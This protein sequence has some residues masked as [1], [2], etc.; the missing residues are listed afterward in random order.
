MPNDE[1]LAVV[2]A[3]LFASGEPIDAERIAQAVGV[4]LEDALMLLGRLSEKY[5]SAE[6]GL[7]LLKL[8]EEYQISTKKDYASEIR[9]ALESKKSAPLSNAAMEVLAI[10]AYNQPVTKSFVEHV[11]GVD[12]SSVVNTLAEKGLLEEA[13]RLE[14]PGRPV[15]YKTTANFLRCFSLSGLE[16]LPPLP[17]EEMVTEEVSETEN[18]SREINEELDITEAV[19]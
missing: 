18:I 12:S 1:R 17:E 8:G 4:E 2:E 14:V 10:A 7:C 19:Q 13:G 16:D 15:A 11:R 6:S 3:I 5:E 9:T